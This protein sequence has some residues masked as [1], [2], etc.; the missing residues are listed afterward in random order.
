MPI[1]TFILQGIWWVVE[2]SLKWAS[3]YLCLNTIFEQT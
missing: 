1:H 3:R 2:R